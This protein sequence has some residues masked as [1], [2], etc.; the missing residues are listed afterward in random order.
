[1][2]ENDEHRWLVETLLLH[3]DSVGIEVRARKIDGSTDTGNCPVIGGHRP[4]LFVRHTLTFVPTIGEAKTRRDVESFHTHSQLCSYFSYL[5]GE[6]GQLYL[7]VPWT[8][9]DEMYFVARRC[10]RLAAAHEVPFVILG[11]V[12]PLPVPA[13]VIHG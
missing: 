2:A 1:M 13:R 7:A 4:D 11:M 12:M 10:R 8:R 5:A 3:W 6:K 9:L